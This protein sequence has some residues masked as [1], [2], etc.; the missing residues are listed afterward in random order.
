MKNLIF[1]YLHIYHGEFSFAKVILDVLLQLAGLYLHL[2]KDSLLLLVILGLV[3][4]RVYEYIVYCMM[5]AS[6]SIS[7][8][9]ASFFLSYLA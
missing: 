3:K 2:L 8:R 4:R 5:V 6:V 7:S 9:T 1:T